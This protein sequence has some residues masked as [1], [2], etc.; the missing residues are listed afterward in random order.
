M[1]GEGTRERG[2]RIPTGRGGEIWEGK[3]MYGRMERRNT[4]RV[5]RHGRGDEGRGKEWRY[6][7]RR[8]KIKK[9]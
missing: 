8:G 2:K 4:G 3:S 9:G 7:G 1:G 5:G 6:T